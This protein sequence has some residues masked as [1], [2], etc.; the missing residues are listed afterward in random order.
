MSQADSS[1]ETG[2]MRLDALDRSRIEDLLQRARKDE[3]ARN[4]LVGA[5]LPMLRKRVRHWLNYG[6]RDHQSS[7][8]QSAVRR[9]LEKQESLPQTLPQLLA[10]IGVIVRNRCHDEW[11]ARLKQPGQ[12]LSGC[13]IAAGTEAQNNSECRAILVFAALQML[14]ERERQV[15]DHTFYDGMSSAQIGAAMTISE[16]AVRV[17]R[18]RALKAL[19]RLLEDRDECQ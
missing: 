16:G 15:L 12:L 9:I 18:H 4:E 6:R 3:T 17:L 2:H 11:R 14:P 5:L 10:W 19:K 7:V 13:D 1:S 8:L